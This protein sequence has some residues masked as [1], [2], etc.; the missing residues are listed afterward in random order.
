MATNLK[1]ELVWQGRL[2]LG[3]E[4]GVYGD[5]T[6]S[7]LAAE[8]PLT[9]YRMD[10]AATSFDVVLDTENLN[11]FTAFPGHNPGHEITIV[12]YDPHATQPNQF[13][14]RPLPP[15]LFTT[16]DNNHKVIPVNVGNKTGPFR[17]SV[18]F[19][20]DTEVKPG[21]YDDFVWKRLSLLAKNFAFYASFGFPS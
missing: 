16:A 13:V 6:Y 8:L 7:G 9:V 2:H 10:P 4:P 18:R 15:V 11:T 1:Q 17:V 5:A 14:E 3:D 21:L 20:C 19:R 12:F